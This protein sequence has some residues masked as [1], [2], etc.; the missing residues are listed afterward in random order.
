[1]PRVG[2]G[3]TILLADINGEAAEATAHLLRTAGYMVET[4]LVDV[5]SGDSVSWRRVAARR[6]GCDLCRRAR[7]APRAAAPLHEQSCSS[8]QHEDDHGSNQHLMGF[9]AV[10]MG[11][12]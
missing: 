8:G 2:V 10:A 11:L 1:M 6:S 9:H 3:R 7:P 12:G 5:A 4:A